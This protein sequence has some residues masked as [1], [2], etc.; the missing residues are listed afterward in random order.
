MFAWFSLFFFSNLQEES[1]S[2]QESKLAKLSDELKYHKCCS[3]QKSEKLAS[4]HV[5]SNSWQNKFCQARDD[6][7]RLQ[8]IIWLLPEI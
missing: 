3:E 8:G 1:L 6:A 5:E 4:A 2:K 7:D